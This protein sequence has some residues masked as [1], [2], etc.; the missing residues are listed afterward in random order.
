MCVQGG[1]PVASLPPAH[2]HDLTF[3][4]M[5]EWVMNDVFVTL[6]LCVC[7]SAG[8]DPIWGSQNTGYK[9]LGG[10]IHM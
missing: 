4:W 7:V 6:C 3:S 2:G 8:N 9:C 1:Q 10:W 5:P